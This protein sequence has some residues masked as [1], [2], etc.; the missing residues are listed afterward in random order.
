MKLISRTLVA[1]FVNKKV[2][3]MCLIVNKNEN[4]KNEIIYMKKVFN[5]GY[6]KKKH[7]NLNER[8]VN[9]I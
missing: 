4:K 3:S 2:S 8:L 7:F 6:L 5:V 9:G 1:L